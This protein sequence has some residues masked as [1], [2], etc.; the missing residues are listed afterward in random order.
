MEKNLLHYRKA[1][2][3]LEVAHIKTAT[4][5]LNGTPLLAVATFYLANCKSNCKSN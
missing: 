3:D 5:T 2:F 1:E 4:A